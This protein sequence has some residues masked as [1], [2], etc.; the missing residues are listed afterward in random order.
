M[1]V[2]ADVGLTGFVVTIFLLAT[3]F[4]CPVTDSP[5]A[6]TLGVG[7]TTRL[8]APP[9]TILPVL[10]SPALAPPLLGNRSLTVLLLVAFTFLGAALGITPDVPPSLAPPPP[11]P[12]PATT[13][14]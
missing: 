2:A 4:R 5:G 8:V 12:V 7:L 13:D 9:V 6:V 11:P 1:S 14:V 10:A 3:P